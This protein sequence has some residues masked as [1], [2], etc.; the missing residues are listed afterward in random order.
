MNLKKRVTLND[1]ALELNMTPATVSRALNNHP[2]ISAKTKEIVK[3][4]AKRL[5][6]NRNNIAS[7]LRSG[8]THVIGVLIPTAEHSFFGSVVHGISNIASQQGYDVLIYQSNES[9]EYEV[10]GLKAF[11]SARVDGIIAS[12]AKETIDYSHYKN[13]KNKNIPMVLFDRVND[14]LGIPSVV[15]DDYKGAF[16]ATE[17]LIKQGYK[18][19][20]HISGP[21][22]IKTFNDRLK[23]YMGALQANNVELDSNLICPGNISLEAGKAGIRAL[24]SL[25]APADAAFAVEDTTALGALKE[26]KE[27][28]IKVPEE[29]GLFGFCNDLVGEHTTPGLSSIDQQTVLMGQE[30]FKL[31]FSII[32]NTGTEDSF[33]SKIVLDPISII[34]ES[35]V[36]IKK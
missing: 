33:K 12:L 27:H 5:D 36:R 2:E 32:E 11:I 25:N 13:V 30:S 8:K 7:S 34:R 9:Y 10:K 31:L 19:I 20:A 22:H 3:E 24:L 21:Q 18:R 15:I 17:H 14:D 6:Y 4:A 35:S 16:L 23:G 1:L 26:L 28:G 29:F